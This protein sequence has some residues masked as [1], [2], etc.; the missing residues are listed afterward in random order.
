M[1]PQVEIYKRM[2][3]YLGR[4]EGHVKRPAAIHLHDRYGIVQHTLDLGQKLVD[5][6]YVVLVPDLFS[7]FTR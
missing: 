5:A 1:L 4:P 6:G 3:A 2:T 7:R